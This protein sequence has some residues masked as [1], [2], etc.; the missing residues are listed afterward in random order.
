MTKF[1]VNAAC[2]LYGPHGEVA[3][4]GREVL[5]LTEAEH[6]RF[7][8]EGQGHKLSALPSPETT[9]KPRRKRSTKKRG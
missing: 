9:P 2:I 6:Q 3:A 5:E 1:R 8:D 4:R 7:V